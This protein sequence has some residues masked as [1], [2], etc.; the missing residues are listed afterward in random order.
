MSIWT[1]TVKADGGKGV[2]RSA[3]TW[4][5]ADFAKKEKKPKRKP[6]ISTLVSKYVI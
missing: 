6:Q 5:F 1:G 2:R 4:L 3:W